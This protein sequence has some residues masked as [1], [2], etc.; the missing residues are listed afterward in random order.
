MMSAVQ[1]TVE[2]T[3]AD[4]A[5]RRPNA[6]RHGA[7]RPPGAA[8]TGIVSAMTV[9]ASSPRLSALGIESAHVLWLHFGPQ[10]SHDLVPNRKYRPIPELMPSGYRG[11][12]GGHRRR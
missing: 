9:V 10:S 7:A 12:Y 11:R 4:N 3:R 2:T 5:A 1:A 8:A 6:R